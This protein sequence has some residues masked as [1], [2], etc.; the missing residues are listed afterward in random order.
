MKV[1][2]CGVREGSV[3]KETFHTVGLPWDHSLDTICSTGG[4]DFLKGRSGEGDES[5]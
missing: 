1:D 2:T 5:P 4:M 3:N